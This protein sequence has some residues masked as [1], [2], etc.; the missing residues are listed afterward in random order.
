MHILAATLV[1][2]LARNGSGAGPQPVDRRS[3]R[4]EGPVL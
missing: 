4:R 2:L 1:V 3:L